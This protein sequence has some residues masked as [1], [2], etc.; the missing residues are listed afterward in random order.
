MFATSAAADSEP[1]TA[2]LEAFGRGEYSAALGHFEAAESAGLAGP[3]VHYNIA[4]CHFELE[5]FAA[6]DASFRFIAEQFEEMRALAIY[7]R[8]LVAIEQDRRMDAR[9]HFL[10]AYQQSDDQTLK[11]LAS[12]M[13][14]RT[15]EAP[16]DVARLT[17][18][19]AVG[20]GYDDNI[21]LRDDAGGP[22]DTAT[23]SPLVEAFGVL[24]GPVAAA[25]N[26][27]FDAS[28][29]LISYFDNNDFNQAAVEAGLA[30]QWAGENWRFESG[31]SAGLSTFGG[32]RF[33]DTYT[34]HALWNYALTR[35][36][37]LRAEYRYTDVNAGDVEFEGVAGSRQRAELSYRVWW[38]L[39]N[40]DLTYQIELN[41]RSDSG[42]SAS[43]NGLRLR[44]RFEFDA[45]WGLE[46]GLEFRRS[47]F[48][49]LD[50]RRTEDRTTLTLGIRRTLRSDWQ[51]VAR[52]QYMDN[53]ASDELFSYSRNALTA[54]ILKTF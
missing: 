37:I 31:L 18:A 41:D 38:D 50:P 52:Y 42:V 20:A 9:R 1:W 44:Y 47:D 30:Y 46:A 5:N 6:A 26:L 15:Q 35:D 53:D 54:G 45:N 11:T 48:D 10:T 2:G 8:G 39:H 14:R 17:G 28:A 3:A 16:A 33:D 4:V 32:D 12:T 24:S 49:D 43:R 25:A 40:L 29:Y 22:A 21:L 19:F 13:L 36:S 51:L 34:A 23:D 27:R 7:N